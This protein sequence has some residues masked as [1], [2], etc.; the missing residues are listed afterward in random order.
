M[1]NHFFILPAIG[2]VI[3]C[4]SCAAA[5]FQDPDFH[6]SGKEVDLLVAYPEVLQSNVALNKEGEIWLLQQANI[7]PAFQQATNRFVDKLRG[8]G[9]LVN[10]QVIGPEM[11]ISDGI[12]HYSDKTGADYLVLLDYSSSYD[13]EKEEETESFG[14]ND[15]SISQNPD[16]RSESIRETSTIP[17][18]RSLFPEIIFQAN[19][20]VKIVNLQKICRSTTTPPSSSL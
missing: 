11:E 10:L 19:T 7:K 18:R 4:L 5:P 8:I 13:L 2:I 3:L 6:T 12:S 17:D 20:S 16:E 9:H 15:L 14:Q 1:K